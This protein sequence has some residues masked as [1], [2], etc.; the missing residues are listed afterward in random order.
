MLPPKGETMT[1]TI[2][3]VWAAGALALAIGCNAAPDA[4]FDGVQRTVAERASQRVQWFQG[5]PEDQ[6]ARR[7]IQ[8]ML[9]GELT[10]EQAVQVAL[11]NNPALQAT[12]EDLGVAQADL[13]QA[14]LL[15]NP[16]FFAKIRVPDTPTGAVDQEYFLGMD[17]V[18]VFL[19]PLRMKVAREQLEQ[20]RARVTDVVLVMVADV[21]NACYE[22]DAAGQARELQKQIVAAGESAAEL[23]QRERSAGTIGELD[24]TVRQATY[25]ELRLE[26]ARA[27]G[28]VA[29]AREKL[30][31]LL[32][33]GASAG[34]WRLTSALT[35]P[36]EAAAALAAIE[37]A[38]LRQRV[39]LAVAAKEV[40][41]VESSLSIAQASVFARVELGS[42]V[43]RFTDASIAAGPQ[44]TMEVPIFDWQQASTMKLRSQ[45]R[46]AQQ[47]LEAARNDALAEIRSNHARMAAAK[48]VA[49]EYRQSLL[50]LQEK[51]V[52]L[53]QQQY[54]A[55]V[56]GAFNLL[57]TKRNEITARK[58]YVDS[59]KEY[60]QA[61]NDLERAIASRLP[62]GATTQP[63]TQ[64]AKQP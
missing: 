23:A 9:G 50:P 18:Q 41:V 51:I 45:L 57:E 52:A 26:L 4:G 56:E 24:F 54:K 63:T 14:G 46:Q 3:S 10:V 30:A 61:R 47:R 49:L 28:Q 8:A 13:V 38:G 43:E 34:A 58:G 1:R 37:E 6:E 55:S 19:L 32:G 25:L 39:D 59:I 27:E 7:Q 20:A 2:L 17:F 11:L 31:K 15:K 36:P 40:R 48:K 22:L 64:V 12:Y 42:N 16:T 62:A 21:R 60:W 44:L 53:Y 5:G 35:E 33:P 29:V